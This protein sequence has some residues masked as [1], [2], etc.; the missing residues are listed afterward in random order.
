VPA[1]QILGGLPAADLIEGMT[2][3]ATVFLRVGAAGVPPVRM[4]QAMGELA[5]Q[6]RAGQA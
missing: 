3:L 5:V 4:L 1:C 2:I 6:E